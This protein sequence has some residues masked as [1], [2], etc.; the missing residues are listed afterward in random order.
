MGSYR[1]YGVNVGLLPFRDYMTGHIS[2]LNIGFGYSGSSR[3]RTI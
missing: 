3:M 2:M 1:E